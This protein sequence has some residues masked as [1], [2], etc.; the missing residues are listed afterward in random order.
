MFV[1]SNRV[2]VAP[3][4]AAQFE[5]R[6]RKRAG[7]IDRQAGFV[8]LNIL[9]PASEGAPYVV[10]TVWEDQRAFKAWIGSED[11]KLAHSNPMPKEAFKADGALEQHEIIIS[12]QRA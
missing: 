2:F 9:R 7:Q 11:F 3:D 12:A 5:E 4:F 10:Q 1:V 6:F 8:S